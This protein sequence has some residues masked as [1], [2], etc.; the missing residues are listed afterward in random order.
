MSDSIITGRKFTG[1]RR[2]PKSVDERRV[3][4]DTGCETVLSKYNRKTT[5]YSHSP[6][7]F[8]R[9]RGREAPTPG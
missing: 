9:V 8:P 2:A 7:R 1:N 6:V 5:C 3:C 4:S